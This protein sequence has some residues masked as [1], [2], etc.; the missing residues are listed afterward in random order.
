M[1]FSTHG[2]DISQIE[3]SNID[4]FGLWVLVQN[5]EYFLPYCG[6][7]KIW[8]VFSGTHRR[9]RGARPK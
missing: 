6:F 2:A 5:Q 9:Q 8:P 4:Q 7:R 1:Q 3:V